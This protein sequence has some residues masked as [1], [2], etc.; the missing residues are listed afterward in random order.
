MPDVYSTVCL[1]V[2]LLL[3]M[4]SSSLIAAFTSTWFLQRDAS[5]AA[6]R[7]PAPIKHLL[8][9]WMR[10]VACPYVQVQ[11]PWTWSFGRKH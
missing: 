8:W 10:N 3:L 4:T 5:S 2:L 1:W 7:Q 6:L 11:V 9:G